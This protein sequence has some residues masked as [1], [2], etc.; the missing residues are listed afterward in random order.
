MSTYILTRNREKQP[1]KETV[2]KFTLKWHDK[3]HV[4]LEG[5]LGLKIAWMEEMSDFE[6]KIRFAEGTDT[7]QVQGCEEEFTLTP[8]EDEKSQDKNLMTSI[9]DIIEHESHEELTS[10][11]KE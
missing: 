11:V 5:V 10:F 8:F 6:V 7:S 1:A 9:F 4:F 3:A 2:G